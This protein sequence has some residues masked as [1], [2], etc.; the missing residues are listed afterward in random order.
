MNELAT[1]KENETEFPIA[2]QKLGKIGFFK[3]NTNV[4]GVDRSA[5]TQ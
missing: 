5:Y 3:L 2:E 4:W 1:E